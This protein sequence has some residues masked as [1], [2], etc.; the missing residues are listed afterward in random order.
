MKAI[1]SILT[2]LFLSAF[3]MA[4]DQINLI[5]GTVSDEAGNPIAGVTVV[6]KGTSSGT[7][8]DLNGAYQL[9]VSFEAK[10]LV[11]SFI[12][13]ETE[14]VKIARSNRI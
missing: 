8:T 14:E 9:Q 2:V 13:Y 10:Y 7:V 5:S 11:F 12:G 4:P 3:S 1:I 6:V